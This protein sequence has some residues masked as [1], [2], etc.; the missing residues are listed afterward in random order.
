MFCEVYDTDSQTHLGVINVKSLATM[1]TSVADKLYAPTVVC[2]NI[3]HLVSVKD[4]L[5]V[6][7]VQVTTLQTKSNVQHGRKGRR[8]LKLN[9]NRT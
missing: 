4:L 2:L 9:V 6:P 3:A 1:N 8:F 5:D 7:T